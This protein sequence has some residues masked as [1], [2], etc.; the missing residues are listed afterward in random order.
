MSTSTLDY[1][2]LTSA[3]SY[4]CFKSWCLV[5]IY[6]LVIIYWFTFEWHFCFSLSLSPLN[7]CLAT[8]VLLLGKQ[9]DAIFSHFM[10]TI[11]CFFIRCMHAIVELVSFCFLLF[12]CTFF[13]VFLHTC[14][15]RHLSIEQC[16]TRFVL[17]VCFIAANSLPCFV[18][19]LRSLCLNPPTKIYHIV[20]TYSLVLHKNFSDI[21]FPITCY[22][23]WMWFSVWNNNNIH[24]KVVCDSWS[25]FFAVSF[26]FN[27]GILL[28]FQL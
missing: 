25:C 22:C 21:T 16:T 5:W 4:D 6:Y 27:L 26:F 3:S 10:L 19:M 12:C 20:S 23:H 15:L 17:R 9:Q 24:W 18:I 7:F 13:I 2:C 14:T 28:F 8:L 1:C 11:C